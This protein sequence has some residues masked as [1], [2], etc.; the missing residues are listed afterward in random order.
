[1][2]KLLTIVGPTATGK[3]ALAWQL[4][5]H[6]WRTYQQPCDL[7]SADSRQVYQGLEIVSGLD[8]PRQAR[9]Q[10]DYYVVD[11]HRLWGVNMLKPTEE[12]SVAHFNHLVHRVTAL[13]W[14]EQ[15]L[16]II[17]GGTGLY[18]ELALISDPQLVIAP[19]L[20]LR[21]QVDELT[22]GEL[23]SWVQREAPDRWT[24]LNDSDR[25]NP[26][27]LV[28]V[29]E[30][31]RH[32]VTTPVVKTVKNAVRELVV[33]VSLPIEEIEQRIAAR[34]SERWQAGALAEI[35]QLQ[36]LAEES[37]RLPALS[38]TGV[39]QVLAYLNDQATSDQA[40]AS[41]VTAERQYAKRQ[42]TWWKKRAQVEWFAADHSD[43]QEQV[44]SRIDTWY[45]AE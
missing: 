31:A 34:V 4:A 40:Q 33:G 8:L 12:W 27:R 5:E 17:V 3:T 28:R 37:P 35:S 21:T 25:A 38:S 13:S 7:I 30:I 36:S 29:L 23:Q 6:L 20:E 45:Q 2:S 32:P 9:Q 1:M 14:S 24:A 26:R 43:W 44:L 18:S 39:K 22:L 10:D 16:P 42:I 15:R 11:Q 19:D 41:W